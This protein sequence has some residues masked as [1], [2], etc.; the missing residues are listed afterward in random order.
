[1]ALN[2]QATKSDT[3]KKTPYELVFKHTFR[4]WV[5]ERTTADEK[6]LRDEFENDSDES[7]I[8]IWQWKRLILKVIH[9]FPL[10]K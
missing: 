3:T 2:S 10:S 5:I 4:R 1:M 9:F 7:D 6:R 8:L